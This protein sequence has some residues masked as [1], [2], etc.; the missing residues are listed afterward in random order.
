MLEYCFFSVLDRLTYLMKWEINHKKCLIDKTNVHLWAC[1]RYN[2]WWNSRWNWSGID[3]FNH[4]IPIPIPPLPVLFNSNSNSGIETFNSN[5]IPIPT[6]IDARSV[7]IIDDVGYIN[8]WL[9]I[10]GFQYYKLLN[11][12]FYAA[13]FECPQ[14]LNIF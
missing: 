8:H 12:V 3:Q 11:F 5:S 14:D 2:W 10:A 7:N 4:S 6:G 9:I 13:H 1:N